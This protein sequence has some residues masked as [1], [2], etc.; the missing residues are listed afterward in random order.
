MSAEMQRSPVVFFPPALDPTERLNAMDFRP[1]PQPVEKVVEKENDAPDP[2]DLSAQESAL[3]SASVT[4][5]SETPLFPQPPATIAPIPVA[6]D[7][8]KPKVSAPSTPV[9]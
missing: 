7:N 4:V 9:G 3:S 8:G 2:K 6:K 5:E 1:L